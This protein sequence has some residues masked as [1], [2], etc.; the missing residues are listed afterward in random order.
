MEGSSHLADSSQDRW[1]DVCPSS[2][3]W[4]KQKTSHGQTSIDNPSKI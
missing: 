1:K 3:S 2:R 4:D